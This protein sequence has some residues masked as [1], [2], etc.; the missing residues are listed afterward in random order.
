M[1]ELWTVSDSL[2]SYSGILSF[3]VVILQICIFLFD[4]ME[5]LQKFTFSFHMAGSKEP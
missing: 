3:H 4:N 1:C 5:A 2:I